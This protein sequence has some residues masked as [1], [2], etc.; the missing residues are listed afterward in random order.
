MF[1]RTQIRLLPIANRATDNAP[2]A[3][4]CCNACRTCVQTNIIVLGLAGI[5]GVRAFLKRVIAKP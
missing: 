3:T 1:E 4:A 5:A 2:M